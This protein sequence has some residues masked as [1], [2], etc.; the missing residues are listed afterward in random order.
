MGRPH[1]DL[2]A[3]RVATQPDCGPV[4]RRRGRRGKARGPQK[5]L[6]KN[7]ARPWIHA[8]GRSNTRKKRDLRGEGQGWKE[9][10]I[11]VVGPRTESPPRTSPR[12]RASGPPK[13]GRVPSETRRVRIEDQNE[14]EEREKTK[15]DTTLPQNLIQREIVAE[16]PVQNLNR[17]VEGE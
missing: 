16:Q 3:D 9:S 15:N 8:P 11:N 7:T 2:P 4:G 6:Q 14:I 1:Q 17:Q 10:R 13:I 12:W 5:I